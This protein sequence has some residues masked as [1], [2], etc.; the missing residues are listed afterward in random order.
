MRLARRPDARV[1]LL[2]DPVPSR[3]VSSDPLIAALADALDQGAAQA[4][5]KLPPSAV[6]A[7]HR[8]RLTVLDTAQA[9]GSHAF[10]ISLVE[11]IREVDAVALARGEGRRIGGWLVCDAAPQRVAGHLLRM[12]CQRRDGESG[13]LRLCDPAVLWA[14]WTLLDAVQRRVLLGPVSEWWALDPEGGLLVFEAEKSAAA[15]DA[16]LHLTPT[17]WADV[18]RIGPLH[19]ALREWRLQ[20]RPGGHAG[21]AAAAGVGLHALRRAAGH[22][23]QTRPEQ[24][25]YACHAIAFGS[26]L[27]AHPRVARALADCRAGGYGAATADIDA[28]AWADIAARASSTCD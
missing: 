1:M 2:L 3:D 7:A 24:A 4:E 9:A 20:G 14:L 8:P 11:A 21:A 12:S 26:R 23:L 19:D 10:A 15:E 5:L 27:D 6:L 13:L 17:Q 28:A 16:N 18:D 25:L 22:G